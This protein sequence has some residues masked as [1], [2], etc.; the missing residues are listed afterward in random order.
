MLAL[1]LSYPHRRRKAVG[2]GPP[3]SVLVVFVIFGSAAVAAMLVYVIGGFN[4]MAAAYITSLAINLF[5]TAFA[6][7]TA[8]DVI[9][10]RPLDISEGAQDR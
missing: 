10:G 7:V 2:K 6:F 4:Y 3:P 5:A 1:L 8:L 9:M